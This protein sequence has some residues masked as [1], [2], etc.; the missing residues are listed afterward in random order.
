MRLTRVRRDAEMQMRTACG[1]S[2]S[3]EVAP[4]A[5]QDHR[6]AGG[7]HGEDFIRGE[8]AQAHLVRG[9]P[10]E[11]PLLALEEADDVA[12][13][14]ARAVGEVV[15]DLVVPDLRAEHL[16]ETPRDFLPQRPHFPVHGDKRHGSSPC[17]L[18]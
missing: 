3:S 8:D 10:L 14:Q 17:S 18:C 12:L 5:A 6:L 16:L 2:L 11:Q 1:T 15:D 4:P 13:A 9:E 7:G